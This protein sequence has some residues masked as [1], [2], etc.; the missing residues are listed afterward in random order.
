MTSPI[1]IPLDWTHPTAAIPAQGLDLRRSATQEQCQAI[2]TAL[3]LLGL[4]RL[5]VRYRI[6]Q[7]ARGRFR[8]TGKLKVRVMQACVVTLEP[9]AADLEESFAA[10]FWPA[11]T[12]PDAT[13]VAGSGGDRA[14]LD[15]DPPE[16]IEQNQID[17]GRI[18]VETLATALDPFPRAPGAVLD[19]REPAAGERA[20]SN[21]PAAG[22][23]FAALAKLKPRQTDGD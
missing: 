6:T 22:N 9:V 19:W 15:D 17:A 16:P 21:G 18:V 3:E 23:P 8:L 2:A 1:E 11:D 4:D 14:V 10:E 20:A 7:A 5:D 12:I 13:E